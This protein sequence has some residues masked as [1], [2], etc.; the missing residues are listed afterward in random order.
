MPHIPKDALSGLPKAPL[1]GGSKPSQRYFGDDPVS[2]GAR[3]RNILLSRISPKTFEM[4]SLRLANLIGE[5]GMQKRSYSLDEHTG[6]LVR[7]DG[8]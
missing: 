2:P 8:A 1:S 7:D 5:T 4:D 6:Q 3:R